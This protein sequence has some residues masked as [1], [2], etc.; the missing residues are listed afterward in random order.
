MTG[1]GMATGMAF[2]SFI[3]VVGT[4]LGGIA[5]AYFAKKVVDSIREDD[6]VQMIQ[7]A[8]E[9]FIDTVMMAGLTTEEFNDILQKTFLHKN[10]NVFLQKMY[11]T[12]DDA[13][14]FVRETYTNLINEYYDKRELPS[15][16][17][18]ID[19]IATEAILSQ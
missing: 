17:E 16:D 8:K 2:G 3:P 13:M 5:G 11:S 10:F 9:E 4:V 1:A 18:I 7:I 14:R 12:G 19:V 15:P 6:A